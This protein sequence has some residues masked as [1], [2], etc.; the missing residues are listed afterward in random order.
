[1]LEN[2]VK[3]FFPYHLTA[4]IHAFGNGHINDTYKVELRNEAGSYILQRINTN[5]FSEPEILIDNHLQLQKQ[6]QYK[7]H[8]LCIADLAPTMTG[9]Y[10]FR[11]EK[12]NYWRMTS[13]IPNSYSIDT[14]NE[15]WQALEAGKGFGWFAKV[16]SNLNTSLFKEAIPNFH[17]LSFRIGQFNKAINEN[18]LGRLD[19]VIELIEFYKKRE[20]SLLRV[21]GLIAQGLIP[22]RILH[23]DT[24]INNLLFRDNKVIAVVDLDTLGPGNIL[25][26]YGDALR[27]CA[28]TAAEDEKD[29]S[30]VGFN[31]CTFK[32][33]TQGYLSQA[34]TILTNQEEKNLY[35]APNLMTYIMGIRFLT[36]Y[37][38]GDIYY[39]TAY[40]H[41]NLVR[42]MVH[43]RLLEDI[44]FNEEK[45][46]S[47]ISGSMKSIPELLK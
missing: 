41:H 32:C 1:M 31:I 24:K 29:L 30:K 22:Q 16:C 34:R 39:K 13:F 25:Y 4:R 2:I 38:N 45:I 7:G 15:N 8:S 37:L 6:L 11:D 35:I 5:V 42:S 43:R 17:S 3:K 44:E 33:F 23:N 40:T 26:D 10:L 20:A 9:K 19:L 36:D 18:I 27:S 47:I 14:V 21:E 12:G 46:K 28:N